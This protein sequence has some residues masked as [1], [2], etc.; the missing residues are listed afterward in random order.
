[1]HELF[2][3]GCLNGV[4]AVVRPH[5]RTS[6]VGAVAVDDGKTREGCAR[7]AVRAETANLDA[8]AR[9]SALEQRDQ[10]ITECCDIRRN[11]KVGPG[12]LRVLPWRGPLV[13]QVLT[14]VRCSVPSVGI[15]AVVG[16][17]P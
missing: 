17:G 6:A 12:D 8:V 2:L 10:L 13:V 5:P 16:D 3:F 15:V 14:E 1:M 9:R 4:L 7:A 11:S